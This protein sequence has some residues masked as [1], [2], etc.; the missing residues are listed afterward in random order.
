M[1][2]IRPKR[3]QQVQNFCKSLPV[4]KA[5]QTSNTCVS[6]NVG[7]ICKPKVGR[8]VYRCGAGRKLGQK[9]EIPYRKYNNVQHAACQPLHH[10]AVYHARHASCKLT[11]V[12]LSYRM[13]RVALYSLSHKS[14][15]THTISCTWLCTSASPFQT[16]H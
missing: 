16:P 13:L 10:V 5:L 4:A 3:E 7:G 1:L 11:F 8:Q 6:G 14:S 12:E 9:H 2:R 15:Y